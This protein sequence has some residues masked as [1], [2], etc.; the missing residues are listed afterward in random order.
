MPLTLKNNITFDEMQMKILYNLIF[1]AAAQKRRKGR[2]ARHRWVLI[3]LLMALLCGSCFSWHATAQTRR[4]GGVVAAATPEAAAAGAE[5]LQKGGNAIDAAVAISFALAVTEPA[6][7]GLGGQT[8]ILVFSPQKPP[9]V[10]NGTS[11]SPAMT[12]TQPDSGEMTGYRATTVPSTVRVLDF[13]MRKFGS[14]KIS[15]AQA[16]AP[17]IRYAERGF[18]VGPYRY[19][20]W[21]RHEKI[22]REHAS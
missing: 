4:F 14:G 5:M 7:S 16:L 12:P 11:F 20:V 21:K 19:L 22:L 2:L 15:W 18:V 13:A 8:Q 1:T 10:I 3:G 9:F 17:A 6:M